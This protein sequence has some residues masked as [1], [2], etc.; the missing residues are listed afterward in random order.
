MSLQGFLVDGA[1]LEGVTLTS[2]RVEKGELVAQRGTETLRGD[3]LVGME[4]QGQAQSLPGNPPST[5]TVAYRITEIE[6]EDEKYDLTSTGSTYLYTLE[7]WVDSTGSWAP[8]CPVDSDGRRAAIP[9]AAEWTPSGARTDA[10]NLFTLA[11]TTGVIAKCYRWG[12][13]PWVTGYGDGDLSDMHWTCTRL[14]RADY[15]GTGVSYTRDGTLINVWDD[16]PAPGPIQRHGFT[17]LGML[18]EAGWDTDG[19]VC[20]SHARY[21]LLGW[22]LTSPCPQQVRP[23]LLGGL[24][25]N[26]LP[27]T[28][29][30]YPS[31]TM[32]S[33]SY[34]NLF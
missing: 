18:F 28:K 33:E 34:L 25:C 32:F 21:T 9:L 12:Y 30:L 19:A 1:V 22:L 3:Q 5:I 23:L 15:C 11:C 6:E 10:S 14:A 8:A 27:L 29:L 20:L 4:L 17:P 2:L 7:Q 16:L 26:T 13:R 31:A 24:V